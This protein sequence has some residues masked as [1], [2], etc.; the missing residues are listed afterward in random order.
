MRRGEIWTMSGGDHY[1]SKARPAVIVQDDQ[2]E[3]TKSITVCP[4]T[5]NTAEA[6]LF[7]LLVELN[8]DNGLRVPSRLMVD[9]LVSLSRT[10]MGVRIGSLDAEDML[11][12]NRAIVVF[13]GLASGVRRAG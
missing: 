9:K 12:L 5:T 10:K 1:A 7:R 8:E 6:P 2:F 11:R 3:H 13:L 4:L